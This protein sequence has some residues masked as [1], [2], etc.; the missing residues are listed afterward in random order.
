MIFSFLVPKEFHNPAGNDCAVAWMKV[1]S[2]Q[3]TAEF[4]SL[5]GCDNHL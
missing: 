4:F 2:G 3:L 5:R 1:I